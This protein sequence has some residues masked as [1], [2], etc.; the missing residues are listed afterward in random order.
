MSA[1]LNDQGLLVPSASSS[2]P[3]APVA[4]PVA[5]A[6][7]VSV[8][9]AL[10]ADPVP[11]PEH[12]AARIRLAMFRRYPGRCM[13]YTLITL[14]LLGGSAWAF[15]ADVSWLGIMAL[16]AGLFAAARFAVWTWKMN[17]TQ[18]VI[19]NRRV[20]LESGLFARSATEF[21][22]D[23]ISG[24]HVEQTAMGHMLDVGDMVIVCEKGARSQAI[25]MALPSPAAVANLIRDQKAVVEQHHH[26][27]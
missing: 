27:E 1:I 23:D 21:P 12:E 3:P 24:L 9:A 13:A 4:I 5:A 7:G 11:E 6:P 25:V 16:L 14:A 19:T 8:P 2:A 17:R 15:A 26:K 22:L 10:P 20:I 18:L